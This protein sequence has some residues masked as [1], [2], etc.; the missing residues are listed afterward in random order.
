[1]TTR[2]GWGGT[3]GSAAVVAVLIVAGWHAVLQA[4]SAPGPAAASATGQPSPDSPSQAMQPKRPDPARAAQLRLTEAARRALYPNYRADTS[5]I[6]APFT[7]RALRRRAADV[8]LDDFAVAVVPPALSAATPRT[9]PKGDPASATRLVAAALLK[10]VGFPPGYTLIEVA[11]LGCGGG[12]AVDGSPADRVAGVDTPLPRARLKVRVDAGGADE[13]PTMQLE[14]PPI[15]APGN[16]N[17]EFSVLTRSDATLRHR[18]RA[19]G[20]TLTLLESLIV[21]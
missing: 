9:V 19:R 8:R 7:S 20:G 11:V 13:R 16:R 3:M 21:E 6:G 14:D 2:V 12:C 1:M 17:V 5:N 10:P 4:Q 18:F 15:A